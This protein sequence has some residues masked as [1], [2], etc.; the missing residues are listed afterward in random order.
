MLMTE[1]PPMIDVL[2]RICPYDLV[3]SVT[4]G[5]RALLLQR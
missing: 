1:A 2:R 3:L 5:L 4:V